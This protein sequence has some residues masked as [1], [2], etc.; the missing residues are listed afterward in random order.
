M[1]ATR[2]QASVELVGLVPLLVAVVA[3]AA[4][5]LA[6][7]LSAEQADQAAQAGAMAVLQGSDPG[8]A[9]RAA[10][11]GWARERVVVRERRGRVTVRLRPPA[12][13]RAIGTALEVE[14][15]A[16]ARAGR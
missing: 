12:P 13:L 9:A 11:P 16:T 5:M 1:N 8:D 6:A 10:V 3:A 4:Q 14:A 15:T 2:A 7:G